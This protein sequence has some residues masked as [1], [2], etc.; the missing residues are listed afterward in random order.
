MRLDRDRIGAGLCRREG[1]A[2]CGKGER[3]GGGVVA[4]VVEEPFRRVW[5][6]RQVPRRV[7]LLVVVGGGGVGR[8]EVDGGGVVRK[9]RLGVICRD[10]G[11]RMS[12][13]NADGR[14]I[15]CVL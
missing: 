4:E 3:D 7:E 10:E 8:S 15:L 2:R 11:R 6:A 5:R 9:R 1:F 12:Q 14:S 13:G